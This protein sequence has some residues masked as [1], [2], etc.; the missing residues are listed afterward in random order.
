MDISVTFDELRKTNPDVI[1]DLIPLLKE[2][3]MNEERI[4]NRL[5]ENLGMVP[6]PYSDKANNLGCF[7]TYTAVQ[8]PYTYSPVH[9][10]L[11]SL[12]LGAGKGSIRPRKEIIDGLWRLLASDNKIKTLEDV[13][14]F[15]VKKKLKALVK[16]FPTAK[17]YVHQPSRLAAIVRGCYFWEYTKEEEDEIKEKLDQI[18][19]IWE[20]ER[21]ILFPQSQGKKRRN[22]LYNSLIFEITLKIL[23]YPNDVISLFRKKGGD[24]PRYNE[25]IRVICQGL[26]VCPFRA[27]D[28]D[29]CKFG[30]V[31]KAF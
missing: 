20:R 25:A 10:H 18:D 7:E 1:W 12:R 2:G 24:N 15:D 21:D 17:R 5:K 27:D 14:V 11:D 26:G 13:S 31:I 28:L 4:C 30:K 22:G 19:V 23:G 3:R 9:H 8:I 29:A 16:D 6:I